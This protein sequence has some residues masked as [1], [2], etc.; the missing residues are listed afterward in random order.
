MKYLLIPSSILIVLL[1]AALLSADSVDK[2]I[3]Q[4]CDT[5]ESVQ[6]AAQNEDWT[7]AIKRLGAVHAEWEAFHPFLHIIVMHDELDRVDV[8]FR[9]CVVFARETDGPEFLADTAELIA[10]LQIIRQSQE[11]SL[12]NIL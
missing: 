12:R 11:L 4:W 3:T 10:Q 7:E 8:L 2:T 6:H 5:L 1:G 9:R